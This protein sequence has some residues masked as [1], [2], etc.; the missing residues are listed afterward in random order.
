MIRSALLAGVVLATAA[1]MAQAAPVDTKAVR[2]AMANY[3]KCIVQRE[4]ARSREFILSGGFITR[5]DDDERTL[6][7]PECMPGEELVRAGLLDQAGVTSRAK[8]RLPDTMVRWAIG[9]ALFDR[10][11]G[12]LGATD[13]TAVPA[14]SY[15]EPYPVRTTDRD[16]NPISA[17]RIAQQQK[18]FDEK[19]GDV[20]LARVGECVARADAAGTRAAL[21]TPLDTPEELAALKAV[22]PAL[23]NC[24]PKGQTIGFDRMSLRGSLAV[25]YYRLAS[26]AQPSGAAS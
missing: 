7:S 1:S 6:L 3:G 13:F 18:K 22:G 24:L 14:L 21:V 16:G 19:K 25:A 2:K 12:T 26:A 9:Q 23:A 5:R 8:L 15:E 17:E 20:A 4:P 10:D 11:A